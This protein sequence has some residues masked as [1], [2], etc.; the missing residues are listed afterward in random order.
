VSQNRRDESLPKLV[1]ELWDLVV[2]YAKQETLQPLK[3]IGKYVAFGMA[4][5]MVL[6]VGVALL[7]LASLRVLQTETGTLFT[8]TWTWI[9]YFITAAAGIAVAFA[10][11]LA[12]VSGRSRRSSRGARA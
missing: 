10:A 3:G 7:L 8:G 9:P 11:V 6:A 2:A 4:G 12:I 5:S 1:S